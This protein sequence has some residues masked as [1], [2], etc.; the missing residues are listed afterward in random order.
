M[1]ETLLQPVSVLAGVGIALE[2]R[3]AT[4]GVFCLGD[5]LLHLPKCYVDDRTSISINEFQ[6]GVEARTQAR[7]MDVETRGFGKKRQILLHLA[8]DD[9]DRL[10]LLFFHS[11]FLLRDARVKP[12]RWLSVRGIPERRQGLWQILHPQWIPKELYR[13]CWQAE[14][15][16]LA[17]LGSKRLQGLISKAIER[18]PVESNVHLD[19]FLKSYPSLKDALLLLHNPLEEGPDSP[20]MKLAF[21]R[22][23]LEEL[24]S[25]LFLMLQKKKKAQVAAQPLLAGALV[26]RFI[27]SLPYP[28]TLAQK[29]VWKEIQGDLGSGRRMHRLLQ[30]DVG[31]GKTWVAALCILAACENGFQSAIM[32]PT[33]V[34]AAQHKHS[35][36]ELFLPLGIEVHL[37]HGGMRVGARR[38]VLKGLASGSIKVVVGTHALISED[39]RFVRLGLAVIDEQHRFGVRQRWELSERG[40]FVHLLAMTA[41]PIPR[42]LALAL[43]GDMDLSLMKGMPP[44]R[45]PVKTSVI[46]SKSLA[47]LAE[48]MQRILAGQGRIYW[49]VP[50]I[51]E[52]DDGVSVE[53]RSKVLEKK[54]PEAGVQ[55][56]HG[57]MSGKEKQEILQTFAGGRCKILVSTTVVEVGVNVVE[58]NLIIIEQADHYGL[59][60]LHQLR[61][62]VGRD[63]RQGYCVLLL[64]DDASEASAQRLKNMCS[65]HNGLELAELDL[66]LRGAGDAAGTRQSGEAAFRLLDPGRDAALIRHWHKHLP[67]FQPSDTMLRF[68][69]LSS[70][71]VD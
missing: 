21:E 29:Q 23:Q 22:I 9:G 16:V 63:T 11:Q 41:T 25:Y 56:L 65:M 6:E 48:G 45:K 15:S 36:S 8:D 19:D 70:E 47:R 12:G 68:W 49:I 4:R 53:Q 54:F 33:E 58:A 20:D 7:V 42:S 60:Q 67:A 37:L 69:R 38:S 46:S 34:L 66:K 27:S 64:A 39:V 10:E 13:G 3:L 50:R 57:R 59:A 71:G 28:L 5:L 32:A 1:Y 24:L 30:G 55:A 52:D 26:K 62:R 18:L 17:G 2:K 31:A 14:Y 35:L 40:E 51:N 44:G 61:G 43:Y